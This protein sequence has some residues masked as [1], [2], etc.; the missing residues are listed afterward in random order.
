MKNTPEW[1]SSDAR[2]GT[3]EAVSSWIN[4]LPPGIKRADANRRAALRRLPVLP[5][6]R[7]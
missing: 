5:C 2:T 6:Q 4:R 3:R 1:K 7:N